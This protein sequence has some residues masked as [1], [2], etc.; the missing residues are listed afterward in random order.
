MR[1]YELMVIFSP[2][3]DERTV[4]PT[5]QKVLEVVTKA[6]GSIDNLDV[7]GRRRM[8]YDI[9]KHS[10]GVYAVVNMHAT[11]EA[12][13]EVSRQLGLNESVLRAK[14]LRVDDK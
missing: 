12:A 3:V 11:S 5:L 4:A 8:A 9:K 1:T 7:W 10:E 6:K 14:M 13:S 2:E